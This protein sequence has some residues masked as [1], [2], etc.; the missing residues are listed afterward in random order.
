MNYQ[1][2]EISYCVNHKGH[3]IK[4]YKCTP[5]PPKPSLIKRII[6]FWK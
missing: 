5:T 4:P 2:N 1:T 3:K 6:N